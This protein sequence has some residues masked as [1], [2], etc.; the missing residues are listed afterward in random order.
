MLPVNNMLL[1]WEKR[2]Y[3]YHSSRENIYNKR[4]KVYATSGAE[5]PN[6]SKRKETPSIYLTVFLDNFMAYI[7]LFT[8]F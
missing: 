6:Q 7:A 8:I 1:L 5:T 4:Q 2:A 3:L